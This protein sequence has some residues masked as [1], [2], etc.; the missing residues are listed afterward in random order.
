VK[1]VKNSYVTLLTNIDYLPGVQALA[2]SLTMC[3]SK[4]PLIVLAVDDLAAQ[5]E[6]A[7]LDCTVRAVAPLPLSEG[8]RARHTRK[9]QH[10]R[11]PFTKGN[12]PQFHD[13]LH[14]FSKLRLWELE[15]FNKVV[16]LD[17]DALVIRNIDHLFELDEFTAAPN[18]Y[19]TMSDLDRMNSGVFIAE[20]NRQTFDAMLA[21][22]DRPDVFWERTDQTFLQ[23]FFPKW[24]PLSYVYNTLQYVWFN[25]PHLWH[26]DRI[27]VIHY[28][29]E[30]PW[31][32]N[33]P[34][35]ERLAPLIDAWW[36]V[37]QHGC[38]P[39]KLY[40]PPKAAVSQP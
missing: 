28:Q 24:R 2:R 12:K 34:K 7:A 10:L 39:D 30:K 25:L 21:A 8:F 32:Q 37:M 16:F 20:P 14:N 15:Q 22:L 31:E 35:R 33:N 1:R 5:P 19:E 17:A 18:L 13:P 27:H 3:R 38:L 29:Y 23:T 6:L 9:A 11:A 4:W 26:W 40:A 36:H